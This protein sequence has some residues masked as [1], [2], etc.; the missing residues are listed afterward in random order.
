MKS[1]LLVF[2]DLQAML[3]YIPFPLLTTLIRAAR[4]YSPTLIGPVAF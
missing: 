4:R 2:K 3:E 1:P